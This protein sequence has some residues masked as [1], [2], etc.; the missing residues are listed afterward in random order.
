MAGRGRLDRPG[1]WNGTRLAGDLSGGE[2]DLDTQ[3]DDLQ[4]RMVLPVIGW[5]L[6]ADGSSRM[7]E[8]GVPTRGDRDEFDRRVLHS[9]LIRRLYFQEPQHTPGRQCFQNLWRCI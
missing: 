2:K 9:S 6:C 4:W 1:S 8:M 3:L 5:L 7:Q